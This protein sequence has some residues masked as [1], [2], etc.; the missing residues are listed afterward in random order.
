MRKEYI[1]D[2]IW[3]EHFQGGVK[4]LHFVPTHNC[5][6]KPCSTNTYV[7]T[8]FWDTIALHTSTALNHGRRQVEL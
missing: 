2:R 7:S 1:E 8:L 3:E 5:Y 4:F 6:Q